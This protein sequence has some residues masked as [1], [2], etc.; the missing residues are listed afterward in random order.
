MNNLGMRR[1]WPSEHETGPLPMKRTN[2]KPL[3]SLDYAD[4]ADM[5][6]GSDIWLITLSDLLM[7]LV[8]FFVILFGME[9]QKHLPNI[10]I[11]SESKENTIE[12]PIANP[13]EAGALEADPS[14]TTA[15]IEKDLVAILDRETGLQEVMVKRAANLVTLTFPERI[16]FDP[17]Y[18]R[19]KPSTQATLD[20]VAS[21]IMERPNLIVE[22]QGHT[23]DRPINNTH[24]P[25]NWELSVD[26]ATQVAKALIGLGVHPS[27]FS[28]KGYGEYR[29]LNANDSD[30]NRLQ[31][32]RVEIQFSLPS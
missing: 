28:V 24:Y 6:R 5:N 3:R 25:S 17:G 1:P 8:I 13:I 29:S 31:N 27:R 32:R 11:S 26:R 16:V 14:L 23:D 20:K 15:S 21:F 12:K 10:S 19:L 7:L 18:A 22:V 30:E 4:Y 9:L 2:P